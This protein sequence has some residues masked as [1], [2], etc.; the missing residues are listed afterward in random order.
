MEEPEVNCDMH[1]ATNAE[2]SV[3]KDPGC[4]VDNQVEI[5][6][7]ETSNSHSK[8]HAA[9]EE[10][11]HKL[12]EQ[13]LTGKGRIP[14]GMAQCELAAD[15]N[16][17]TIDPEP[18]P[19][20]IDDAF[21]NLQVSPDNISYCS[22]QSAQEPFEVEFPVNDNSDQSNIEA[23]PSEIP[24]L[25]RQSSST[26]VHPCGGGGGETELDDQ[27]VPAMT[28]SDVSGDGQESDDDDDVSHFIDP[29]NFVSV[30]IANA[31]GDNHGNLDDDQ[32][33]HSD[34]DVGHFVDPSNFVSVEIGEDEEEVCSSAVGLDYESAGP[35]CGT[36]HVKDGEND[37]QVVVKD[38]PCY[39]DVADYA[40]GSYCDQGGYFD[41]GMYYGEESSYTPGY[42]KGRGLLSQGIMK[43]PGPIDL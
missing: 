23:E 6:N 37:G 17:N 35:E 27:D 10:K 12:S 2:E 39:E 4:I 31:A 15:S 38:E 21:E 43:S 19:V 28:T 8:E 24:E 41:D 42:L 33:N 25:K 7:C 29:A 18:D 20:E 16:D 30:E 5:N 9:E 36:S 11:V 34:D 3:L 32:D 13:N 1:R 40:E 26:T 14:K 22:V